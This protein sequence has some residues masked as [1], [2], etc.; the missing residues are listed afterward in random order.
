MTKTDNS[1]SIVIITYSGCMYS[2]VHGLEEMFLLANDISA[3]N[4]IQERFVIETCAVDNIRGK[5]HEDMSNPTEFFQVVIIPPNIKGHYY[6]NP[7]KKLIDW[8][9]RHHAHGSIISSICAG[10]FILAATG[11]IKQR[12]VTTHWKLAQVFYKTYP[13]YK[14]DIDK[15]LINDGDIITAGG[16]MSWIDLGLEITSQF[17]NSSIMRELGK[18]LVIDTGLREQRYYKKFLPRYD[19]TD[20]KIRGIQHYIQ[21]NY[22]SSIEVKTL[23]EQCFLTERTFLR[24]FVKAVGLKPIQYIQRIRIQKA[25]ELLEASSQTIDSI[26]LK[27]GYEDVSAF[28]R[29]FLKCMNV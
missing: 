27:V 8:I 1:V 2:A 21:A 25:C 16:L 6:L 14:L 18:L 4:N 17:T 7:D 5:Q 19:H 11:L 15:I 24:H 22:E 20:K 29:I 13:D 10:A 12:E 9:K 26:A 3:K 28:R 23:A